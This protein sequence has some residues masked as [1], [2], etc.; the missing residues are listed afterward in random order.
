M[1]TQLNK[2]T[3]QNQIEV[4]K[5]IN[6]KTL[7]KDFGDQYNKQPNVH[8]LPAVY[9]YKDNENILL[10]IRISSINE[11][12]LYT[13]RNKLKD[14]SV[15]SFF[16]VVNILFLFY[17]LVFRYFGSFYNILS[18]TKYVN[19]LFLKVNLEEPLFLFCLHSKLCNNSQ[20]INFKLVLLK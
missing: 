3:N 18:V 8:S 6:K 17:G 1:D 7:L 14:L 11:H 15:C 20:E 9:L 5:S 10:L 16:V 13:Y 2:P 19:I 4:L 12:L